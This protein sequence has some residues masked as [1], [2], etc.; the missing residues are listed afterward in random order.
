MPLFTL[1][2]WT[3][4]AFKENLI[5]LTNSTH[6]WNLRLRKKIVT[7]IAFLDMKT[8]RFENSLNSTWFPRKL[9]QDWWWTSTRWHLEC[10]WDQWFPDW[11]TE[12]SEPAATGKTFTRVYRK[13]KI[14]F[15]NKSFFDPLIKK[16]IQAI[17]SRYQKTTEMEEDKNTEEKLIF[18]QYRVSDQFEKSLT[19]LEIPCKV[20][21]TLR[22]LKTLLRSLKPKVDESLRSKVVYK[23]ECPCCHTCYVDQTSRHLLCRIREHRRRSSP[24][25]EHF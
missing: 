20:I 1:A 24:V 11:F 23:I 16:T 17:V 5:R 4:T 3:K 2:T 6:P 25:G 15:Q 10:T 21:F 22:K 7:S 14:L 13:Q 12:S 18:V 19:K 8:T 9:T